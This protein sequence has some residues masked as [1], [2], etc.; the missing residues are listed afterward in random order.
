MFVCAGSNNIAMCSVCVRE[1]FE[2]LKKTFTAHWHAPT[3]VDTTL[4]PLGSSAAGRQ[5]MDI[6]ACTSELVFTAV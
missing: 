2:N 3:A 1:R 5:Q 4:S 6:I